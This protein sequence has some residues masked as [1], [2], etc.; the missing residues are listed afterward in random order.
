MGRFCV[1]L[2]AIMASAAGLYGA[3]AW[4]TAPAGEAMPLFRK[5]F[6][7]A[8]ADSTVW[9]ECTALG[10][11]DVSINGR[12]VEMGELN[13]GWTDYRKEVMSRTIEVTPYL[14][15]GSNE[16]DIQLSRGWW[17]GEISRGAYGD[18]TPMCVRARLYSVDSTLAATDTTWLCSIDGPL[19]SGDIYDGE[20]YDARRKASEWNNA[21]LY[22]AVAPAVVEHYGPVVAVRDS[23]LWRRPQT[24]VVYAGAV[25]SGTR[26]GCINEQRRCDGG[27]DINLREGET[28]LV[29]FGQNMAGIVSLAVKGRRGTVV[30]IKHGEMLNDTGDKDG[31]LDDGPAG[32]LWTYNLRGADAQIIYTLSGAEG[33]DTIRPRHTFMGFRYAELAADG[34]VCVSGLT[35]MPLGSEIMEWGEFESSD[36]DLERLYANTLWSQRSN[37]LSVPTDCPQ[38]DERLG[39]TG[40]TQ[41]FSRTALYNSDAA[42]FYKKWLRDLRNSQRAD[43]A[44]PDIAPWCNFWGYGTAAWGDAGVIVPWNVYEF[45]ADTTVL[46]ENYAA[47]EHWLDYLATQHE[48]TDSTAWCHIGGGTATGDWLAYEPLDARCVAM[49][50]YVY[51]ARIM[52]RTADVLGRGADVARYGNLADSVREEFRR[53]FVK[54]DGTLTQPTQTA[55]LLALRHELLPEQHRAA[56]LRALQDKI[57]NNGYR[58]STGFVGTPL[59]CEVLSDFG[60]DDMAYTLLQQRQNPSWLYSIDQGATTIWERWDSYTREGGFHKHPWNMNSFNHYAYGSVVEWFYAYMAGIKPSE[61][62]FARVLLAPHVDRRSDELLAQTGG[63]RIT[64]ASAATMTPHGRVESSWQLMTEGYYEFSFTLPEGLP[65]EIAIPGLTEN[66]R[67]KVRTVTY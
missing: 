8:Q 17:A 59:L 67:V 42:A 60:D 47:M 33:G 40:D 50:Y 28:L 55:Y 26:F 7:V 9:L 19:L 66:D 22:T 16:I 63:K 52:A 1:F 6:E 43:G 51:V 31:R 32:S 30:R 65:Y 56:A 39:W 57:S 38:R 53:R 41:I 48:E 5:V 4:I 21:C 2:I 36:K 49:A 58:L 3:Q 23:A 15:A 62:G 20:V 29:D 10:V 25:A 27:A 46:V 35:A 12:R 34:D 61:A 18:Y 13:P 24:A 45:T 11:Y 14:H 37:F 54:E 64:H 44:Y